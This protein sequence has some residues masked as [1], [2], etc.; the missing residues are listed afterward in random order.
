MVQ[1][2]TLLKYF[3]GADVL[4][5]ELDYDFNGVSLFCKTMWWD[6][7][8]DGEK[9]NLKEGQSVRFFDVLKVLRLFTAVP[10]S[11][12]VKVTNIST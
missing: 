1:L 11:S 4:T 8:I 9:G 2:P 6:S 7:L 3:G 10:L 12:S 5:S